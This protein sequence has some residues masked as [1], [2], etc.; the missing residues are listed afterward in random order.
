MNRKEFIAL[1]AFAIGRDLIDWKVTD[2]I[3]VFNYFLAD[4]MYHMGRAKDE[5]IDMVLWDA[6][7]DIKLGHSYGKYDKQIMKY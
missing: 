4:A 6:K 1:M 2:V 3:Y 5:I 7:Q